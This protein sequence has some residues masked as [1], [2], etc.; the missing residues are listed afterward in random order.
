MAMG[1]LCSRV[2]CGDTNTKETNVAGHAGR[3]YQ[4]YL[5]D[6]H[7]KEIQDQGEL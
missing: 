1:M 4:I 6:K 7:Q 5:C 2:G 3:A